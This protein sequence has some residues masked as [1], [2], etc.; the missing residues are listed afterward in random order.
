MF[1]KHSRR[2]P[3]TDP[4]EAVETATA[5]T[6]EQ[7]APKKWRKSQRLSRKEKLAA[8]AEAG[9]REIE[10]GLLFWLPGGSSRLDVYIDH[11][12]IRCLGKTKEP[13]KFHHIPFTSIQKVVRVPGTGFRN[14]SIQLITKERPDVKDSYW[15][16]FENNLVVV[17][18]SNEALADKIVSF[19]KDPYGSDLISPEYRNKLKKQRKEAQR[20]EQEATAQP[21]PE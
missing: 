10:N 21:S 14:G 12:V 13:E 9:K 7:P 1:G 17:H 20:R 8:Q 3:Q 18:P 11:C 5:S 19:L 6:T 2:Q 4:A 15:N 16:A